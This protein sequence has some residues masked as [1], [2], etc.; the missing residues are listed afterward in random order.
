[1]MASPG[2]PVPV[3][4]APVRCGLIVL[5]SAMVCEVVA[6]PHLFPVPGTRQWVLGYFIWR[7]VP[8]SVVCF[9]GLVGQS[10]PAQDVRKLVVLY[11]L[12][13]RGCREYFAISANGDLRTASIGM[14]VT[15]GTSDVF[16]GQYVTGVLELPS[17]PG[18][19]PDFEAMKSAFYADPA[20][21]S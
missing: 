6:K 18:L 12:P 8:V 10:G 3:L 20:S 2:K 9:D 19:I 7:G 5:P 17:G 14:D 21:S 11:P 1:M 13:G 4:L 15:V 16:P